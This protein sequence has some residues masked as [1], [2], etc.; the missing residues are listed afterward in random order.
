MNAFTATVKGATEA[1]GISRSTIYV[2]LGEGA[3]ESRKCGRT[4]LIVMPTLLRYIEEQSPA[5]IAP[6]VQRRARRAA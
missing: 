3:I 1:T 4:T 6:K 2:L 5:K